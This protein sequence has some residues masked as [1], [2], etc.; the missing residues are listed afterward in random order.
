MACRAVRVPVPASRSQAPAGR[1]DRLVRPSHQANSAALLARFTATSGPQGS[2]L[3]GRG[4]ERRYFWL[5]I[6]LHRLTSPPGGPLLRLARMDHCITYF[7]T[8]AEST[9]DQDIIDI[10]EFSRRKNARLA[11]TGVLLY[12]NGQIV[13]VLEGQPQLVQDLYASIKADPRHTNVRTAI[14]QPIQ[15]RLFSDWYMGYQTLLTRQY[16]ELSPILSS[17]SPSQDPVILR[18]LKGFFVINQG[19]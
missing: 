17:Q 13:Q 15:Q 3:L 11:I 16:D 14:D 12:I 19:E 7:S 8:A 10:V 18:M 4:N 9:T 6:L 2:L 1:I 5:Y